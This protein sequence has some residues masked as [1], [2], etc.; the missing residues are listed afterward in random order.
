MTYRTDRPPS[1]WA[2]DQLLAHTRSSAAQ[3]A[4]WADGEWTTLSAGSRLDGTPYGIADLAPGYCMSKL[5]LVAAVMCCEESG[6]DLHDSAALVSGLGWVASEASVMDVLEHRAGLS[7]PDVV[8]WR[9][10]PPSRRRM[11]VPSEPSPMSFGYSDLASSMVLRRII[12]RWSGCSAA[13]FIDMQVV[14][15]SGASGLIAYGHEAPIVHPGLA[16]SQRGAN[17]PLLSETLADQVDA[18][19]PDVG[20]FAAAEGLARVLVH[21]AFT[22]SWASRFRQRCLDAIRRP[23]QHDSVLGRPAAYTLGLMSNMGVNGVRSAADATIGHTSAVTNWLAI[24]DLDACEVRVGYTN[25]VAVDDAEVTRHRHLLDRVMTGD[26]DPVPAAGASSREPSPPRNVAA[27][28]PEMHRCSAPASQVDDLLRGRTGISVLPVSVSLVAAISW[29]GR[30]G[31]TVL[32]FGGGALRAV[33]HVEPPACV[34]LELRGPPS[35]I[36]RWLEHP[37]ERLGTLLV[38][39][40]I[41][42]HGDMWGLPVLEYWSAMTANLPD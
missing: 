17:L 4:V 5:L 23:I 30:A 21:T 24:A 34:D 38:D 26:L 18:V 37:E 2:L 40:V 25:A 11:L 7:V 39:Q 35:V 15:P 29:N 8:T 14:R 12:E 3:V 16:T 19:T 22:S 1:P 13:S 27:P 33:A 6:L 10:T 41:S 28:E 31:S 42:V 36:L 32:T 9:M 20:V